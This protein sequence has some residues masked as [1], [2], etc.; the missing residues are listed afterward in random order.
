MEMETADLINYIEPALDLWNRHCREKSVYKQMD[1]STFADKFTCS[2]AEIIKISFAAI[3]ESSFAGFSAGVYDKA[4]G[5]AYISYILVDKKYRGQKI[6]SLL[7][8][9]LEQKLFEI[10]DGRVKKYEVIFFNPAKLEWIIPETK[11]DDHPNSP[12]VDISCGG[13]IFLK[14]CGY[15]DIA[16]QNSYYRPLKGFTV[17]PDIAL[18]REELMKNNIIFEYY[19]KNLHYDLN[20]LFDDL[21]NDVW[22]KAVLD[23]IEDGK[24]VIVVSDGGRICGYAGPLSVQSSMRGYFEGIGVHSAYRH[25]GIGKVLFNVLCESLKEKGAGFMSLFTGETNPARNIYESAG[26]KI[27]RVWS[28]MQKEI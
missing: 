19:D 2:E 11:S 26:F 14:N 23:G 3:Y 9:A 22:R 6:G 15:R 16:Y 8:Q 28:D 4:S 25:H 27:V 13:Y 21:K 10:S 18:K 24:P 5:K 12:G 20:E 1:R 7:L 17:P